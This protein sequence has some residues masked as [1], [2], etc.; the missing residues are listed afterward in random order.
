[1]EAVTLGR[2][3]KYVGQDVERIALERMEAAAR[4][5]GFK[6]IRFEFE[7]VGAALSFGVNLASPARVLVFDFGGGTLDICVMKFPEKKVEAVVGRAIGGDLLNSILVNEKLLK[8]F[9]A[10]VV[11]SGKLEMPRHYFLAFR[12]WFH[13]T[14]LKNVAELGSLDYLKINADDPKPVENLKNLV[15]KD[16][17]Y[18]LFARVD[19]AKVRLS[20]ETESEIGFR[21][22]DFGFKEK[23]KREEFEAMIETEVEETKKCLEECLEKAGVTAEEIDKVLIT[24]GSSKIPIFANILKNQW[25]EEKLYWGDRFTSVGAGLSLVG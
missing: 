13:L 7:P 8:Y 16:Y 23:I 9:G 1:L 12:N 5:V 21:C 2:P 10:K 3:V 17:G 20:E 14:L 4:E 22:P 18:D 6:E 25:G 11:I 15:M 24:G 19:E